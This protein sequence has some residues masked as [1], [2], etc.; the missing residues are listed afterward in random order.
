MNIDLGLAYF[1]FLCRGVQ[2]PDI[3]VEHMVEPDI[4]PVELVVDISGSNGESL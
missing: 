2:I 1:S 3:R 4:L